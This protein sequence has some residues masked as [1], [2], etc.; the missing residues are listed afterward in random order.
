MLIIVGA[1]KGGMGKVFVAHIVELFYRM[2]TRRYDYD[3]EY[4][5]GTLQRF[6]PDETEIVD[7]ASVTDQTRNKIPF[8]GVKAR[9][10]HPDL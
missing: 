4:P 9:H 7:I 2:P 6:H 8:E 1:D 10:S 5:R 3:T